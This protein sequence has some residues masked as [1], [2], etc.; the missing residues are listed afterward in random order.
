LR[1][2]LRQL[3]SERVKNVCVVPVS[4]VSDHVETL[5]EIEHEARGE[6]RELGIEHFEMTTGLNDSPTFISALAGLVMSA[7]SLDSGTERITGC[8]V[9]AD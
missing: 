8:L 5:G 2:T 4:F 9:A 7:L 1:A 6:A 3:G